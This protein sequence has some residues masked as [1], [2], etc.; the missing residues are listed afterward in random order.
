MNDPILPSWRK[1][2]ARAAILAFLDRIDGI[3]PAERVAVFDNDGTLMC[4]KPTY[5]QLE[6]M[7]DELQQAIAVDPSLADRDEFHALVTGDRAAQAELGLERIA[8]ALVSLFDGLTPEEF[9]ARVSRF[10]AEARHPERGVPFRQMRYQPMLELI[11]ELRSRGFGVSVV[12]GGGAEFVRTISH[13]FYGVDPEGVVGSQIDYEVE[14]GRGGAI[15]LVRTGALVGAGANEG[16]AKP[17]NIQRI[18][19]RRPVVAGGNSAGDAE[20][21]DYAMSYEGPS[22]AL[23]VDHDDGDREYAYASEAAT[24]TSQETILE[25]ASR[26]GWTVVSM[27]D[28]WSTVFA[29]G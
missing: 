12:T 29:D 25:T 3:P 10:F 13:D 6:F 26:R 11:A 22:L 17:P 24:F 18:L 28:D 19:G 2:D 7:L 16:P 8:G 9:D 21:L 1:G 15:R 27:R 23:L 4:E 14:A 20:M 5:A